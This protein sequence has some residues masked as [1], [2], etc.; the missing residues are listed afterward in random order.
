MKVNHNKN[1]YLIPQHR[2]QGGEINGNFKMLGRVIGPS[3][4]HF[5]PAMVSYLT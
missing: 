2:Y 3:A 1:I 5:L 4:Q